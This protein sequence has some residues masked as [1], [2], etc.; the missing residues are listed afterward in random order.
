MVGLF[1]RSFF[2]H[3]ISTPYSQHTHGIVSHHICAY[4]YLIRTVFG[5]LGSFRCPI[6]ALKCYLVKRDRL[7]ENRGPLFLNSLGNVPT[8][9]WFLKRFYAFFASNK[10]GHSMRAGGA[11]AMAQAGLPMEIIQDTGR[12]SSEAFKTYVRDHPVLRLRARAENPL[13]RYWH[14]GAYVTFS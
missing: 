6:E 2:L 12:W 1:F 10:S 13:S 7:F 8:R 11:S 3:S 14:T 4:I 9:A 5:C